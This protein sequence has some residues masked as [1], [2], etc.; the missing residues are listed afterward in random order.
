MTPIDWYYARGN[1][2]TGPVSSAELKRLAATGEIRPDDLVWR[3]GLTEWAL[4]RSVRSLFENESQPAGAGEAASQTA[5]PLADDA[6]LVAQPEE[7]EIAPSVV[8]PG[9]GTRHVVDVLFDRLRSDAGVRCVETTARVFRACGLHGLL[10]A[11]A[12]AAVFAVIMAT[13]VDMFGNLLSGVGLLVFL[14]A[15]QYTAGKCCDALDRLV[16]TTGGKLASTLLPDCF[17]V[18]SLTAG[19]LMVLGS[20]RGAV[21]SSTWHTL[22]TGIAGAIVFGHAALAA[23]NPS[24]LN[25]S[26]V[27]DKPRVSE[28]AI[29]VLTFLAKVLLRVVPVVLGTGVIVGTVMMGHACYEALG[30]D[31]I[32]SV[33][34]FTAGVARAILFFSAALPLIVY[35]LFLLYALLLDL[36]LAIFGLSERAGEGAEEEAN[37]TEQADR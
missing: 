15:L 36:C 8:A 24:T 10:V 3:E 11:M 23:L 31:G 7:A 32:P 27:S 16:R 37:E 17:A 19:L 6:E 34:Q 26:I 14:A 28:E 21:E 5:V 18:L 4:A 30:A 29:G 12:V 2:Q 13:K 25:I 35:A 1:K 33:A 20:A 22:L 9:T